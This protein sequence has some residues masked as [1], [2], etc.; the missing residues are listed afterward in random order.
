MRV[1]DQVICRN[2]YLCKE[3]EILRVSDNQMP[4]FYEIRRI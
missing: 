3:D 4:V 1:F 2:P